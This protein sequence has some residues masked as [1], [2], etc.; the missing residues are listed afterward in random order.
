M[1]QPI[2]NLIS[3]NQVTPDCFPSGHAALSWIAAICAL[4]LAPRWG[5]AATVAAVLITLATLWLRYH[6][7]VDLIAAIPLLLFGLAW[8]GFLRRP[9]PVG[10][11]VES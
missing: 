4:R 5:R 11:S 7:L 2:R 10:S 1:T 9:A 8:G 3:P 6:Y